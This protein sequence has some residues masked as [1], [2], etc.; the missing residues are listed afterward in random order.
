MSD[1]MQ[2][3]GPGKYGNI[4][5]RELKMSPA[6]ENGTGNGAKP[7]LFLR[8]SLKLWQAGLLRGGALFSGCQKEINCFSISW[9][10]VHGVI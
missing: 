7:C 2:K 4:I 6:S 8:Y 10:N 9:P 1:I 3:N 5:W